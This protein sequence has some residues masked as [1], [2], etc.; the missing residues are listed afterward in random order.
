MVYTTRYTFAHTTHFR[1]GDKTLPY[2]SLRWW[3]TMRGALAAARC[4]AELVERHYVE[5]SVAMHG[6]QV[7]DD[8]GALV[9]NEAA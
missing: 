3:K 1:S 7:Y 9:F 6:L 8:M 5:N 4:H 2:R